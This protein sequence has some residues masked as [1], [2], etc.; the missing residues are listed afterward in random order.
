MNL[1]QARAHTHTHTHSLSAQR[2]IF[3]DN[4]DVLQITVNVELFIEEFIVL[5]RNAGCVCH[6]RSNLLKGNQR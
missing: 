1:F 5:R 6:V 4:N 2:N 3:L